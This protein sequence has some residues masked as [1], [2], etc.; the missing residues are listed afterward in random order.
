MGEWRVEI[1]RN[2]EFQVEQ[3]FTRDNQVNQKAVLNDTTYIVMQNQSTQGVLKAN[4]SDGSE[5]FWY[6][7]GKNPKHGIFSLYGG[8]QRKFSYVPD[9]NF[10]GLDTAIVYTQDDELLTGDNAAIVFNVGNSTAI[11]NDAKILPAGLELDNYPNPFNPVTKIRFNLPIPGLVNLEI[12]D[13]SGKRIMYQLK[14]QFYSVGTF[15]T[16][17]DGSELGSGVYISKL[18]VKS[19]RNSFIKSGKMLLLN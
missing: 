9:K 11:K 16:V 15:E 2:N 3:S 1:Y 19:G 5:V 6:K 18:T 4:D 12:F 10:S 17:F 13:T 14:N 7:T 8:R